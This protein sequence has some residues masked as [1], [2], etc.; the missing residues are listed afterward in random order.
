[1]GH[2]AS[3]G[4]SDGST[5]EVPDRGTVH[6]GLMD[7]MDPM[8]LLDPLDP[9]DLLDLLD[10]FYHHQGGVTG[11]GGTDRHPPGAAGEACPE[12]EVGKGVDGN[13]G[14]PDRSK[15]LSRQE[16]MRGK[17]TEIR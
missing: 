16:N 8:D 10:L 13:R 2:R 3:R 17:L 14:S 11:A 9:M 6:L 12:E 15:S 5:R 1:M 4:P 7:P